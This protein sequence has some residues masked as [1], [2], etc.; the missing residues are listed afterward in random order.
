M[1]SRWYAGIRAASTVMWAAAVAL[2][3]VMVSLT[4]EHIHEID[5]TKPKLRCGKGGSMCFQKSDKA[6]TSELTLICACLALAV[7]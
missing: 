3:F 1:P 4:K 5:K 7:L 2:G 6:N